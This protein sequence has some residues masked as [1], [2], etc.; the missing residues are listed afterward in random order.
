MSAP[1]ARSSSTCSA[2]PVETRAS[3]E[4]RTTLRMASSSSS[5]CWVRSARKRSKYAEATCVSTSRCFWSRSAPAIAASARAASARAPRFPPN[6]RLWLSWTITG[7]V[8]KSAGAFQSWT[9]SIGSSSAPAGSTALCVARTRAVA[10]FNS[11][12]FSRASR[13]RSARRRGG[14]A[15]SATDS[16]TAIIAN[17]PLERSGLGEQTCTI[18]ARTCPERRFTRGSDQQG[19]MTEVCRW[20]GRWCDGTTQLGCSGREYVRE[21]HRRG[22]DG[23]EGWLLPLL[24]HQPDSIERV[25]S[26]LLAARAFANLRILRRGRLRT[27]DDLLARVP[28]EQ[29]GAGHR[30]RDDDRQ[31][32]ESGGA[33]PQHC[34]TITH[35]SRHRHDPGPDR[36]PAGRR[37]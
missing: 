18:R 16:S 25:E 24:L 11:G 19:S 35:R 15:A 37:T 34:Q 27:A 17:L 33:T 8:E 3:D 9:I 29:P 22:V 30:R 10:A 7:T 14:G 36:R 28:T 23:D 13:R 2:F 12:F 31:K 20:S 5:I 32:G 4:R 26:P 6:G 1:C 21:Q